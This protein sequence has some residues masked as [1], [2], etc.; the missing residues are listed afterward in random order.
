MTVPS[1]A[2]RSGPYNGNGVTTVFN[3]GFRILDE[4]H[5]TVIKTVGGVETVLVI[6]ADYIV[7]DVGADAGGQ[8]AISPAPASGSTITILRNVPF[9]QETDLENQGA[10][11]AETIEGALDRGVMRDQ[12]LSERL[13][14]AVTIPASADGSTLNELIENVLRLADS[15]DE[16]DVVASNVGAVNIVATNIDAVNTAADNI[17]AVIDAPNQAAAAAQSA[18]DAAAVVAGALQADAN[19]ADLDDAS[20]ARDNLGVTA[21]L[22][23]LDN[24]KRDDLTGPTLAMPAIHIKSRV[25]DIFSVME[26]FDTDTQRDEIRNRASALDAGP[27]INAAT[28]YATRRGYNTVHFPFG[29]YL[30]TGTRLGLFTKTLILARSN[31][32]LKGDGYNSCIKLANGLSDI[33]NTAS[34]DGSPTKDYRVIGV[35]ADSNSAFEALRVNNFQLRDLRIDGNGANNVVA[36]SAGGQIRRGYQVSLP[37]GD[38]NAIE[39]CWFE[40]CAGR[41]VLALSS[42]TEPTHT[43]LRIVG[44]R[45]HNAGAAISGNT[46][47]NDHS[48]LY[49]M[50]DVALIAGNVLWNDTAVE[51]S[52]HAVVGLEIHGRNTIVAQNTVS[53]Y[54]R[55]GNAAA[56]IHEGRNNLWIGN[57]A[58]G[59]TGDAI[60]IWSLGFKNRNLRLIDNHIEIDNVNFVGGSGISQFPIGGNGT[61]EVIQD[62]VAVGNTIEFL[63]ASATAT[64]QNGIGLTAADGFR[65]ER[66][67]V[68]R[69]TGAGISLES[70]VSLPIKRGK[71]L[72]NT[73]YDVGL[74]S[75][76]QR[77][78]GVYVANQDTNLFMEDIE[79]DD[80]MCE[81]PLRAVGTAPSGMRGIRVTGAGPLRNITVGPRNR[82]KNLRRDQRVELVSMTDAIGV[83]RVPSSVTAASNAPAS[84]LFEVSAD[85]V[86][87]ATWAA[88]GT[89]GAVTVT[90]GA[91]SSA[92]WAG[93]TAYKAGQWIK[94]ANGRVIEYT[95]SGTSGSS[96]PNPTVLCQQYDDG[97]AKFVYRDSASVAFKTFGAIA[98]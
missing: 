75:G 70:L 66:N 11:F 8:V 88:S 68:W 24:V 9:T 13:D 61:T 19:L 21:A 72:D 89:F 77:L 16:I 93:T 96:E 30:L 40:N 38:N 71:L 5:L 60:K 18:A 26:V 76:G 27:Y 51:Y 62:F 49:V 64:I 86:T 22:A 41:N 29:T 94:L 45:I 35:A 17:G 84:G 23:A 46:G 50:A 7:S 54:G 39:G 79:I 73:F 42:A 95:V 57:Q 6:D 25:H 47:Q 15:A 4:N 87:N 55:V 90:A 2:N 85:Y 65:L 43:N 63:N 34:N 81:R 83:H 3:Y 74:G 32:T 78:W 59:I 10:Y 97:T 1:S 44:N 58:F 12:Q 98:A 92:T 67:T 14:R 37:G 48:S 20:E 56:T 82:Y 31:L 33:A 53:K 52:G 91:A 28:D 36:G 80:N 69:S